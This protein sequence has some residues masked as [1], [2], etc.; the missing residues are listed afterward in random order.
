[1]RRSRCPSVGQVVWVFTRGKKTRG[2]VRRM[3]G[4]MRDEWRG[5]IAAVEGKRG[6]VGVSCPVDCHGVQWWYD[7]EVAHGI[8][9]AGMPVLRDSEPFGAHAA[10]D[11]EAG[12]D[13]VGLL[14]EWC[15]ERM[16]CGCKTAAGPKLPACSVAGCERRVWPSFE[17]VCFEHGMEL[18]KA[19][20]SVAKELPKLPKA[21]DVIEVLVQPMVMVSDL[22]GCWIT[23]TV[24]STEVFCQALE[25]VGWRW[26]IEDA[27][28]PEEEGE[29]GDVVPYRGIGIRCG[30]CGVRSM[31]DA[32]KK[33]CACRLGLDIPEEEEQPNDKQPPSP[34]LPVRYC[35]GIPTCQGPGEACDTVLGLDTVGDRCAVCAQ[36]MR[37]Y[38][39]CDGCNGHLPGWDCTGHLCPSCKEMRGAILRKCVPTDVL[40]VAMEA[41][42]QALS[43]DASLDPRTV[44]VCKRLRDLERGV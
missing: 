19:P 2:V 13:D 32:E 17:G 5:F 31:P 37:V 23:H 18:D 30:A 3:W 4:R 29:S 15:S 10:G 40:Q 36:W 9:D 27:D 26:P 6:E 38:G 33:N 20:R 43:E 12:E 8:V 35:I 24:S 16:P 41:A 14:C 44:A 39:E 21:G 34:P 22:P 7:T 42:W 1:M 28:I 25:G 11:E